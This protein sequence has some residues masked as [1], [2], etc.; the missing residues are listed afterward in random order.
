MLPGHRLSLLAWMPLALLSA[1]GS[2]SYG[3]SQGTALA[4]DTPVPT[5]GGSSRPPVYSGSASPA[6]TDNR[7]LATPA[8][9][10]FDTVVGAQR[11]LSITFASSDGRPMTGFEISDTFGT[12]PAGWSGPARFACASVTSGSGCVLNLT[13]KPTA[14]DSGTLIIK[15]V[16]V[17]DAGL[18]QTDGSLSVNFV[19]SPH[20]NV[21]ATTSPTGQVGSKVG[22]EAQPVRV[23]FTT[24]DGNAATNLL[25]TTDLTALPPGWTSAQS[26][27]SCPIVSTGSGCQ[28]ALSYA[29]TTVTAGALTLTYS[30]F[31]ASGGPQLGTLSIPYTATTANAVVATASPPGQIVAVQKTGGQAVP[32]TFTTDDGKS[33]TQLVVTTNLKALPAGWHAASTPFS[34]ASVSTGNGCLLPLN[35]APTDLGSG[36]L[37]LNYAYTDGSGAA[38][39]GILNIDY[40]ATTNDNVTGTAS[41]AGQINAV[42]GEG[43]VPTTVTFTTDDG[44]AATALQVTSDL[45]SLDPGW[46]STSGSFSCPG[47]DAVSVCALP[48][49]YA[50]TA[51]GSG[52]LTVAYTY[53][54]NAGEAKSGTVDIPYRATTDDSIL[55]H[56][57]PSPFSINTGASTNVTV[58][59][60]TD[61][62]NPASNLSVT[63][64][65]VLPGAWSTASSSFSCSVVDGGTGCVLTLT[66]A[67]TMVES[68]ML[69]LPFTYVNDSG[70]SKSGTATITY[71]ATTPG[72]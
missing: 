70:F 29:G 71:A 67:P 15:Y 32:V 34:C 47:I 19:A 46:T 52:S 38:K 72:P 16:V 53:H 66:Y 31:D 61:D 37:T 69:T 64:L 35:Y 1:C 14:V 5:A 25:L 44:R 18:A 59:F 21:I 45:S 58:T 3:I 40:A 49:T 36:M 55:A 56:A 9:T 51:A 48:L 22:A 11:T 7:I 33:A 23:N 30:Y 68:G 24:D 17:N 43:T 65:D 42:V 26:S 63:G 4:T 10:E 2:G 50:P 13:Y 60:T 57:S 39:T 27:F 41:P 12:L 6:G 20:D 62:S 28:L 8:T 54:N